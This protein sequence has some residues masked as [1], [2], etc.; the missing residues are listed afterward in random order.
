M[1]IPR[2]H[3]QRI[4]NGMPPKDR[5]R[6]PRTKVDQIVYMNFQSGNGGIVLDV[7]S[8]GLGFQA[9]DR[10]EGA[11][12]LRF[13]LSPS[14]I[15][16]IDI[17]GQIMWLDASRKRGGLRLSHL[18]VEVRSQIQLWQ[19]QSL[20][21]AGDAERSA[22]PSSETAPLGGRRALSLPVREHAP[23][24]PEQA[25]VIPTIAQ[26]PLGPAV[27]QGEDRTRLTSTVWEPRVGAAR[28]YSWD[29]KDTT[30]FEESRGR[31]H[32]VAVALIVALLL[33]AAGFLYSSQRRGTGEFFIRLG[34]SIS[35]EQSK[36]SEAK[37]AQGTANGEQTTDSATESPEA[38]GGQSAAS[39][40]KE[41]EGSVDETNSSPDASGADVN[42]N[43][44]EPTKQ[45]SPIE[46]DRENV[47]EPAA[48]GVASP[49]GDNGET[50]LAQARRYLE[51]SGRQDRAVAAQLLWVAVGKGN[52]QAELE[53]ADLYLRGQGVVR[54]NCQQAR[55]LLSA[56]QSNHISEASERLAHLRDYGCR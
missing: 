55:I 13:R 41:P 7:S 37:P 56:A 12:S 28:T 26:A 8:Q 51:G 44:G 48:H 42:A 22:E 35:G 47:P 10:V 9:A 53:L 6:S 23:R 14:T 36:A 39:T 29:A 30:L 21:P 34:E 20:S 18:P 40:G 24:T 31:R 2:I 50:E 27:S 3:D 32:P 38:G 43:A 54:R 16:H 4:V 46:A 11:E 49:R 45:P 25:R 5:R 52:S 15:E 17:T 19:Q 33:V 1:A